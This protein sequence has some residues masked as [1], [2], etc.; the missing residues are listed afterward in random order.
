MALLQKFREAKVLVEA[1]MI[2]QGKHAFNMG[3]RSSFA[4]IKGW[5]Q[6]MAD[7]MSDRGFLASSAAT[8]VRP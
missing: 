6:R 5:P 7:W 3:D 4:A 8:V 2:A 1:H